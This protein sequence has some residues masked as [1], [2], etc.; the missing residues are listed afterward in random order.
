M[1]DKWFIC[2]KHGNKYSAE[3]VNV[4][5]SMFKR[6]STDIRFACYTEDTAGIN[7]EIECFDLPAGP[8]GVQ[9]WW[10]KPLFFGP[11]LPTQGTLL[12]CD[13]DVI[14]FRDINK[15]YE[16]K[17]GEFCII[18]DFHRQYRPDW[19]KFNS[20][21]FRLESNQYPHVYNMFMK[22]AA[23]TMRGF[24]GDQDYLDL[25]LG[26]FAE[27]WPDEW[28]QS[29]K[30]EMRHRAP[31]APTDHGKD[32]IQSSEPTILDETS[33]AVFHGYPNPHYCKDTWVK[34]NWK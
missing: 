5:Y 30:W 4:L 7:P 22:N 18:R 3:Y 19:K 20:S 34:E 13:L 15:F 9:G 24:K 26:D 29:Y 10:Y 25:Q 21:V 32:F 1:S 14:I 23:N 12:F 27:Y 8:P 16:Y 33:I 17:P 28:V 6:N 11:D 31:L 2:L